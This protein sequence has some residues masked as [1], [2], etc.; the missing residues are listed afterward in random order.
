M[1]SATRDI[2]PILSRPAS[3]PIMRV[4][5]MVGICLLLAG[6]ATQR[7]DAI[8]SNDDQQTR[9]VMSQAIELVA[10]RYIDPVGREQIVVNALDGLSAI[11][12]NIRI[13]MTPD[14][15]ILGYNGKTVRNLALPDADSEEQDTLLWTELTLKG[16]GIYRVYSPDLRHADA[17]SVQSALVSG[18]IK[19]LDRYSRYEG[20]NQAETART[21]R[22]G[23]IGVG[24]RLIGGDGYPVI[25]KVHE[26]S[27][28]AKAGLD[29]GDQLIS[30]NGVNLYNRTAAYASDL[31]HGEEGTRV[32][33]EINGADSQVITPIE[34]MRER[35]ISR[36]VFTEIRDN[37]LIARIA[38]FNSATAQSLGDEIL[39]ADLFPGGLRGVILDLRGNRGGLLQ[40]GV[41]VA[42]LF[43]AGGPIANTRSRVMAARHIFKANPE[44]LTRGAPL[45]VLIDGR[46]ASSAELVAAALQDRNRAVLIGS[47][48]FGKG[49]VQ[50]INDLSNKGTLTFTWSQMTAP[51]GYTFDRIGLF[52][53]I[54]T[55]ASGIAPNDQIRS[56]LAHRDDMVA[57]M[58][59]WRK[60]D[61]QNEKA[62]QD[63]RNVCP[64]RQ[65]ID[66]NDIDI[67]LELIK[68]LP[69]YKDLAQ[70][71]IN[72]IADTFASQ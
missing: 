13:G 64:A 58:T 26:D 29:I 9:D 53:A 15:I 62:R 68:N 18:S 16:V 33:I 69:G 31:L 43:I 6:C 54:C 21:R 11:D 44:D 14:E 27:P 30:V 25:K 22:D 71:P 24:V 34:I 56:A 48:S 35:V 57:I 45:V 10:T 32:T 59:K 67:A 19:N 41:E 37:V 7:G 42:D 55:T 72:E 63:L 51:S 38:S 50:A 40:Q 5:G 39:K 66:E 52:P 1:A 3:R 23:Y 61:Y 8:I 28:A 2:G 65:G 60:L 17:L 12:P 4:A 46:T 49:S 47:T 70:L 20:P 36:T